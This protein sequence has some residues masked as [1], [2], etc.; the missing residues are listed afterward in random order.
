MDVY[1][2]PGKVILFGLRP[3]QED[4]FEIEDLGELPSQAKN[5]LVV[6]EDESQASRK[7]WHQD[8]PYEFI[9]NADKPGGMQAFMDSLKENTDEMEQ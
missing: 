6:L 8:L 3:S 7:V 9:Q 5:L 2:S 4:D 1:L